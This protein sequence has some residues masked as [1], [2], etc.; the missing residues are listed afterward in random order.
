MLVQLMLADLSVPFQQQ[1]AHASLLF[2]GVL[3]QR[4][5]S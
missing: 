1:P 2:G 4:V 5:L 3:K